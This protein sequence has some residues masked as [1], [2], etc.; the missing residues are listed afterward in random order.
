MRHKD[1]IEAM[2]IHMSNLNCNQTDRQSRCRLYLQTSAGQQL[3]IH[4]HTLYEVFKFSTRPLDAAGCQYI[5]ES[6]SQGSDIQLK[7]ITQC[8]NCKFLIFEKSDTS[9]SSM[10]I[11]FDSR[12]H[13]F[14]SHLSNPQSCMR[15]PASA[16]IFP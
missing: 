4:T 6:Q 3:Q 14:V 2:N 5:E 13:V 1:V 8:L 16:L 11:I 10:Y 15:F 9:L 7:L 12:I